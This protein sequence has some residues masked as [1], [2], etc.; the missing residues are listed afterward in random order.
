MIRWLLVA[1]GALALTL[2]VIA[3]PAPI[4]VHLWPHGW[5]VEA[6]AWQVLLTLALVAFLLGA[7]IVWLAHLPEKRRMA[8]LE[9]SV[10]LIRD[11]LAT[12]KPAPGESAAAGTALRLK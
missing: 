6:P 4:R 9:R 2:F 8:E 5:A 7:A 1:L 12:R 10:M 3:N 11:D